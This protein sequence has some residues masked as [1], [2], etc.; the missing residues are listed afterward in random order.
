MSK[1]F[2]YYRGIKFTSKNGSY[3]ECH[4]SNS[5]I[6]NGTV[7]LHRAR[8]Q[9]NYGKIPDEYEIHHRNKN[10]LDNRLK[11]LECIHGSDHARQHIKERLE[12]GGDLHKILKKWRKSKTG[13]K[14]LRLNMSKCRDKSSERKSSGVPQE[15]ATHSTDAADKIVYIEVHYVRKNK[16]GT[17]IP[18]QM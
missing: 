9:D 18:I 13:K 16:G 5:F 10:K 12:N 11:N 1:I 4:P 8:W 3:F 15:E 7:L 2:T 17:F 6:F 14:Q